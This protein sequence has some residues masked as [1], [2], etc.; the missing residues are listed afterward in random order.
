MAPLSPE[1]P[2]ARLE[3]PARI[4]NVLRRRGCVT[5]DDVLRLDFHEPVRGLGRAGVEHILQRLAQSGFGRP[6]RAAPDALDQMERSL[7]RIENRIEKTARI[8][9]REL[10]L[11]R[12]AIRGPV[13]PP[14]C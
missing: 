14:L 5:I 10:T 11:L 3:L 2:I 13:Q 4:R 8:L 6:N 12:R 7:Q 1:S 9:T